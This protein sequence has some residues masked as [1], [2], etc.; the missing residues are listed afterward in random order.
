MK[1]LISIIV[2]AYNVETYIGKCVDSILKQTYREWELIIIDDGSVDKTGEI[3]DRYAAEHENISVVHQENSGVSR[4]RNRGIELAHGSYVLFADADDWIDV[5]MLD[6][7]MEN[8]QNAD[9]IVCGINNC[10]L[11]ENGGMLVK[12]RKLWPREDAFLAENIYYDVLCKT[13]TVWN[14]LIR[15]SSIGDTRFDPDM[16][17]GEDI[18]FLVRVI[19]NV[20]SAVIVPRCMYYY[21]KNRSGNVVSTQI[22]NR[23]MQLL[24]NVFKSY[25]FLA[26]IGK[27]IYGVYRIDSAILEVVGK[28]KDINDSS[29]KCYIRKCGSVLR[30]TRLRDRADYL[31]DSRFKKSIKKKLMFMLMTYWPTMALRWR[32]RG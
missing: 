20:R 6:T 4:A 29:T 26:K 25:L 28:I 22:D 15:I 11:E 8:G 30:K 31:L 23:S 7:M 27:G 5:E 2:P 12:P 16:S 32:R 18:N 3:A 9:M 1:E 19:P 21:F 13:G 24:E 10:Y 14:K 17:Y